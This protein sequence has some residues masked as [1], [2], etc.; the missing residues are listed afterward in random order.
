[1][2]ITGFKELYEQLDKIRN[3]QRKL[4]TFVAQQGEIL[5]G[6]AINNT[7]KDTGL[8]RQS[9]RRSRATQSKCEVYNNVEYAGH[10]EYGHRTRNGGFVKGSKMLH[11]AMLTHKKEFIENT[12]DILRNILND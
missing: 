11:K 7:P 9:W 4:N 1:M 12:K 5:R 3:S 6:E 2:E 8:L 10:V